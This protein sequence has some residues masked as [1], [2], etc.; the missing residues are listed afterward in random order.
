MGIV[1]FFVIIVIFPIIYISY[2]SSKKYFICQKCGREFRGG[3]KTYIGNAHTINKIQV[4]CPNCG[5]TDF[6]PLYKVNK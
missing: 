4:T 6:M 3:F 5:Y 2:N 1:I